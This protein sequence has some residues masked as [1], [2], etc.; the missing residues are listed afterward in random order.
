M[1]FKTIGYRLM[2]AMTKDQIAHMLDAIFDLWDSRKIDDLLQKLNKDVATT[3]SRLVFSQTSSPERISSDEKY[4]EE[5]EQ[6]WGEWE[7]LI[8]EVGDEE[9][10]YA[11]QEHHWEEPYFDGY[12][13]AV[14][15]DKVAEKMLPILDKIYRLGIEDDNLFE[16][17]LSTI[18]YHI[19]E[20]PEW[21]SAD[22]EGC[23]L[24][25]AV[26]QCVLKWEWLASKSA[27]TF[28]ERM[29]E[30]EKRLNLIGLDR[31]T[32]TDFFDSLSE[33]DKKQVYE[34]ITSNRTNSIWEERLNSSNSRWHQIYHSF[35]EIF[36][37]D[38]YLDTC[39]ALLHEN[40]HYGLPLIDDLLK[41]NNHSEA[42]KVYEQTI[43]SYAGQTSRKDWQPEACLL[44]FSLMYGYGSADDT[45]IKLLQ[46][47]IQ[48]AGKL[49]MPSKADSL[50]LQI[51]TYQNPYHWDAVAKVFQEINHHPFLSTAAKLIRQWQQFILTIDLGN[52]F[53]NDKEPDDCW[54]RWLMETG[55]DEGKNE[56][57]FAKKIKT[58]LESF[59]RNPSTQFQKRQKYIC[60]LTRDIC[61]IYALKKRHHNLYR[62]VSM[63]TSGY[64]GSVASRQAWLKKMHADQFIPLIIECWKQNVVKLLPDP[65]HAHKSVYE[66]HALWLAVVK[67]QNPSA[68]QKVIDKWKIDHKRRKNLWKAIRK[69]NLAV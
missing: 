12:S 49:N 46:D 6:L 55:L 29:I 18:D 13:L 54:I 61:D 47:W 28:V 14:D 68:Y 4:R 16:E 44:I 37:P 11:E 53:R 25:H 35:S 19:K 31:D 62:I 63:G 7:E 27:M 26:T 39:R 40:W 30:I 38:T 45:V 24:H 17:E 50:K 51:V 2:E 48:V 69:S 66:E 20:Y 23:Y 3:L 56:K 33:Y 36:N 43:V 15:L 57:W 58:W 52:S 64:K 10:R 60:I 8:Y 21:M 42:E 1:K 5:W 22:H 65:S 9:G 41:K 59:C 67:E 32:F 34:H